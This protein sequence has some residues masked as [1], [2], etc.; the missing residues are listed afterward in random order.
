M[1]LSPIFK[2]LRLAPKAFV[3]LLPVRYIAASWLLI[4][5]VL[6]F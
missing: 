6:D 5:Q 1:Q 4:R 2:S 3:F